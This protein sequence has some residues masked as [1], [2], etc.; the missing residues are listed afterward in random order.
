MEHTISI[1]MATYNGARYLRDQLDSFARQTRTPDELVISDDH[2]TDATAEVVAGFARNAPFPV[3][4]EVNAERLGF[5]RNFE[6]AITGCTGDLI[7]VSDQDDEWFAPKIATVAALFD[8]HPD[9]L[10][11]VNDQV[12]ATP[13]GGNTGST[14]LRNVR[15]TGHTDHDYGP[16]CCTALRRPVL[17]LLSPFPGDGVPYDHWINIMP[18]LLGARMICEEPLQNYRRHAS[19]ATGSHFAREGLTQ[20]M[21]AA[22]SIG[23]DVRGDYRARIAGNAMIAAR[24]DERRRVIDRLGHGDKVATAREALMDESAAY[25]ARLACL[26]RPRAARI[27]PVLTMLRGGTY[28]RFRGYKS[29]LKDLVA[30]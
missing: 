5:N 16:G 21:L 23:T 19:N 10:A 25:A 1:A 3:K 6:R 29:A 9:V 2:S 13:E 8:A 22:R 26:D 17:D 30:P 18:A 12:I 24:I 28:A 7:F 14:V 27:G 11:I 15:A 4:F 20:R